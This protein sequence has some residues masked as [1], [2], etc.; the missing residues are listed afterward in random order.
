MRPVLIFSG[1]AAILLAG[2]KSQPTVSV[3]VVDVFSGARSV[4]GIST[5]NGMQLA[6]D[7]ANRAGGV[8]GSKIRVVAYDDEGEPEKSR[9]AVE[10][11]AAEK[12]LLAILGA[13]A[14]SRSLLM[15]PVAQEKKIPMVT[16]SSTHPKVT[17]AGDYIFRVCFIDTFQGPIMARFL[18]QS[19]GLRRVAILRDLDTQYSLSLGEFFKQT[20]IRAGGEVVSDQT[21]VGG[22][23]DYRAQVRTL[24]KLQPE[25]IYVP[26][27]YS[28]I[29][30]IALQA[31]EAGVK[32]VFAGGDG[33]DSHELREL[34]KGTLAGSYFSSHFS[35]ESQDAAY[36]EFKARFAKKYRRDP[37]A[38]SALGYDA[39]RVLIEAMRRA[40]AL[41]PEAVKTALAS[42]KD[43]DG[44][45]GKISLDAQ[46][47]A[48]KPVV[49]LKVED[50]KNALVK[51][52]SPG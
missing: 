22:S 7:E 14:S 12:D 4:F 25:A 42:T 43:F 3:G 33:W 48:V 35:P 5:R 27:Y 52:F 11:L 45:T 39:A 15:A 23:G 40:R 36:L 26:A 47:N 29:A 8:Q 51:A 38:Y 24:A 21:Y 20:F 37:D 9:A 13:S 41:T 10:R 50:R 49:I 34:S 44:V 18:R 28:D 6:I 46:R 16:S 31:R 1:C 2:C 17:Q 32:G 19:L 30:Q